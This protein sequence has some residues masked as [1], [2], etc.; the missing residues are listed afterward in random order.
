LCGYLGSIYLPFAPKRKSEQIRSSIQSCARH[1]L[2]WT[3]R[4][5]RT[6]WIAARPPVQSGR[7]GMP[8]NSSELITIG[9]ALRDSEIRYRRLFETAQDGILILDATSG[10]ITDVNPFLEKLLEY[11]HEE[12]L[13]KALWQIGMFKDIEVSKAAFAALTNDG[14]VRYDDLPLVTKDG[15]CINVEFVSNVYQESHRKVIQCNIRDITDRKQLEQMNE[16]TRQTQKMEAIGQLA[17]G[18]AHDFNNLLGVIL[19]YCELLE[20][21]ANLDPSERKM[22][23]EISNAG[24][25]AKDLTR[26][27]LAFSRRQVVQPVYLDLNGVVRHTCT[28]LRRL[29]GEDIELVTTLR[30]NLGTVK[31]DPVQLEQVLMNLVVNSRDA[32]P[33]GGK[34]TIGT[35]LVDFRGNPISDTRSASDACSVRL[36]VSDSGCGMDE[37]TQA[38]IFEPFFSTKGTLGTGLGLSTV[39]GIVT[40]SEGTISVDSEVGHGTV[41]NIQLPRC[42][43]AEAILEKP[44]LSPSTRGTEMILLVEDSAPLRE[45]TRFLLED[46]GYK[47]LEAANATE[48]FHVADS[49]LGPLPLLITD[50]VLPDINGRLLAGTLTHSRPEMRVLYT[51]GYLEHCGGQ[52]QDTA[53]NCAFLE[54]PYSRQELATTVRELLDEVA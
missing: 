31:A 33:D 29:I 42:R 54:K 11:T 2:T 48:A 52:E 7:N 12:F 17:G 8:Q 36:S 15:A 37:T 34:I 1:Y 40:Q 30:E 39:F 5:I 32:M 18:V 3:T 14:Y 10:Q 13:G 16:R 43:N 47:V 53:A 45:L 22:I 24:L 46:L 41:F 9:S 4:C 38:H 19:G 21:R 23:T 51:S 28:L 27:L 49:H 6:P 50:I 44:K 35:S 25:C 26:R 20:R